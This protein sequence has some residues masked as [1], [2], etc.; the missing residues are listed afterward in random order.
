[1]WRQF[2]LTIKAEQPTTEAT[3][4]EAK[5]ELLADSV[6]QLQ[7]DFRA[8]SR[9]PRLPDL[10]ADDSGLPADHHE[11]IRAASL[12]NEAARQRGLDIDMRWSDHSKWMNVTVNNAASQKTLRAFERE[13]TTVLN[14]TPWMMHIETSLVSDA[15]P[16]QEYF[17]LE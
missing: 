1:M 9:R 8:Q 4:V 7:A 10:F 15:D 11:R 6:T 17:D 13:A 3:P 12:I 2:G 5:L 14:D 16:D